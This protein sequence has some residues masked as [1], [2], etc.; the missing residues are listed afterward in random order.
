MNSRSVAVGVRGAGLLIEVP[1]VDGV[2]ELDAD[3][4][5]AFR[6]PPAVDD[7]GGG[8][9]AFVF[10]AEDDRAAFFHWAAAEERGAVAAG[11][12][13]PGFFVPG[14]VRIFT[15]QPNRDGGRDSR[16]AADLLG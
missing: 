5:A 6:I 1:E 12:D 4:F 13:G 14:L 3:L 2:A 10:A 16:A 15:A 11:A 9:G 8:A 7:L